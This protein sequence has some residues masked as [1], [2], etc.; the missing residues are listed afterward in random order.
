MGPCQGKM[1]ACRA[2]GIVSEMNDA[3]SG[4]QALDNIGEFLQ[5]R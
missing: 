2:A 5:E 1:C 3:D 4:E